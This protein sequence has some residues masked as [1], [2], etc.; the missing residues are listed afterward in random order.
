MGNAVVRRLLNVFDQSFEE[1]GALS[2]AGSDSEAGTMFT[3]IRRAF[4]EN[5]QSPPGLTLG[6][7]TVSRD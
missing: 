1:F 3:H 2:E 6:F 4:S 5:I 7:I